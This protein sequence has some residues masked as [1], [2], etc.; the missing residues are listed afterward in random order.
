MSTTSKSTTTQRRP[1]T[2]LPGLT[3][4]QIKKRWGKKSADHALA[5]MSSLAC[6]ASNVKDDPAAV[7]MGAAFARSGGAAWLRRH[8]VEFG[9]AEEGWA[10]MNSMAEMGL[11]KIVR[12]DRDSW[13]IRFTTEGAAT[14]ARCQFPGQHDAQQREAR[15]LR[16]GLGL[17]RAGRVRVRP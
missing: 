4:A 2:Q 3:P 17:E 5:L 15:V 9:L 6:W 12:C 11:I 13:W 14:F 8:P 7:R 16:E 1:A 10:L